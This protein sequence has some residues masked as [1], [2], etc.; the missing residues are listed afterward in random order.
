MSESVDQVLQSRFPEA[1]ESLEDCK[2]TPLVTLRPEQ[3]LPVC[4]FL[5]EELAYDFFDCLLGVDR[6]DHFD[7][8]YHLWSTQR[9]ASLALKVKLDHDEPVVDS[10]TPVWRGA[11]WH[12]REAYDLFGIAFR[13][14]GDLRRILL[15]EDFEGFPMRKDYQETD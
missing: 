4:R 12:E 15:P 14:H 7:V 1:V 13:G 9:N 8:V 2:G 10:A 6:K 3:L 11:D 5:K